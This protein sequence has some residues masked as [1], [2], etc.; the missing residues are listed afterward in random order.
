MIKKVSAQEV[1]KA[2]ERQASI[3]SYQWYEIEEELAASL[4]LTENFQ[5][6]VVVEITHAGHPLRFFVL[7]A[8]VSDA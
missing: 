1:K 6:G 3:W 8:S 2:R 4:E 5:G 7:V